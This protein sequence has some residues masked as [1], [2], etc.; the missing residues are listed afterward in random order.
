MENRDID[1]VFNP[2][3]KEGRH[4]GVTSWQRWCRPGIETSSHD[5]VEGDDEEGNS[6]SSIIVEVASEDSHRQ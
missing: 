6:I 4:C 3:R 1:V 2:E 5:V